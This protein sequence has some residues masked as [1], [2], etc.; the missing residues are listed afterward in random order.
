MKKII[1]LL[2][3]I[4]T[5]SFGLNNLSAE[6]NDVA[7]EA[8]LVRAETINIDSSEEITVRIDVSGLT[9]GMYA[10][11]INDYNDT[12]NTYNYSD[13]EEGKFSFY[14]DNV[15][16]KIN[17]VIK[18]YNVDTT[19]SVE[20]LNTLSVKTD[21]FNSYS[22]NDDCRNPYGIELCGAFYD[23]GNM[24]YEEFNE[25]VS[26]LVEEESKPFSKKLGSFIAKYYLYIL[27]PFLI[28]VG[29]YVVRIIIL[30]RGK[31]NE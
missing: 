23:V 9:E 7:S 25:K 8:L 10:I 3:S 29:I 14:T 24:T 16:K 15:N 31:K 17:Y 5:F 2:F 27:I 22:M 12:K 13:T 26:A 19:C 11:V 30:K 4:L 1:I 6:C 28:I 18:V 21:K 20:P